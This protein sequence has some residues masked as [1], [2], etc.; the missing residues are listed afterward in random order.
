M[1]TGETFHQDHFNIRKRGSIAACSPGGTFAIVFFATTIEES[2]LL[3]YCLATADTLHT[4]RI[5]DYRL[6]SFSV[7]DIHGS[8][9]H[10]IR[11]IFQMSP[12][13]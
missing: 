1:D 8:H 10:I 3:L 6:I 5:A 11:N 2:P 4:F 13:A 7:K 9:Q 12:E